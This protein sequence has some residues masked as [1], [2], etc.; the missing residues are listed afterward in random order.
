MT[1]TAH[2]ASTPPSPL[3]DPSHSTAPCHSDMHVQVQHANTQTIASDAEDDEQGPLTDITQRV[4]EAL[5]DLQREGI[6]AL[7]V[8]TEERE[9]EEKIELFFRNGCGCKQ[10]CH[11]RLGR[12]TVETRRN[13]C[14]ELTKAE[15]DL[16][17]LGQLAAFEK[18]HSPH[19]SRLRSSFFVS[20]IKVCKAAFLF[21]HRL[22]EKHFK[23]LKHH[24][25]LNGLVSRQHGN[26]GKVPH[27]AMT[28]DNAKHAVTFLF[29]YAE[30]N[31]VLLPGRVPG[32]KKKQISR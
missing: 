10:N 16:V 23:N 17:I 15:L 5:G 26:A 14:A 8:T 29:E 2:V 25:T 19:G 11:Q 6:V 7:E 31:A 30:V 27:N 21:A 28:L 9:E 12:H 20:G 18:E 13:C 1:P 3:V 22:G 24:M 32:Y 4:E